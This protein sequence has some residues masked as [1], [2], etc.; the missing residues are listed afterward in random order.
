MMM[1]FAL[2][3]VNGTK[4]TDDGKRVIKPKKKLF[5]SKFLVRVRQIWKLISVG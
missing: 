2:S 1:H 5:K 4:R 3:R